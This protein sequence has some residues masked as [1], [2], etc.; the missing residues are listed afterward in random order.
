MCFKSAR[1]AA[2][3]RVAS[4]GRCHP[5]HVSAIVHCL[6]PLGTLGSMSNMPAADFV[7]PLT[8]RLH[9]TDAA[10]V[11]FYSRLLE[12]AHEAYEALL[13]QAGLGI[14]KILVQGEVRLPV[15]AVEAQFARPIRAGDRLQVELTLTRSGDHSYQVAYRFRDAAGT[16]VARATTRH[17]ALDA[18]HNRPTALPEALGRIVDGAASG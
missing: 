15:V 4:L 8:V 5:I 7:H 11:I 16:E 3:R 13:E 18:I 10:G 9:H 14:G 17:V 2:Y 1:I 12:L 6:P